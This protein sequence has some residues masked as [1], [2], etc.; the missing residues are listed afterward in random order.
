MAG[1]EGL[2]STVAQRNIIATTRPSPS[3]P[4]PSLP[5]GPCN[6]RDA[7]TGSCGCDQF[8][9]KCSAEIHNESA[10]RRPGSDRSTWC[11]CGHHA[12]FHRRVSR[13]FQELPPSMHTGLITQVEQKIHASHHVVDQEAPSGSTQAQSQQYAEARASAEGRIGQTGNTPSQAST[14]GLPMIPSVCMLS[15]DQD[16]ANRASRH[17]PNESRTNAGLGLS[18]LNLSCLGMSN[19]HH[20]NNNHERS[21]SP[22][23]PDDVSVCSPSGGVLKDVLEFNRNLQ[24]DVPGDTI[25]DTFNPEDYIQSATEVATP[26][27]RNTPDLGA[28]DKAVHEGRDFI[29]SLRRMTSTLQRPTSS[30]SQIQG[31]STPTP[32]AQQLLLTNSPSVPIEQVQRLLRSSSPQGVQQLVSYLGP[33]HNLLTSIPQVANTMRELGSRLDLLES[34]SF[35]YVQPEDLN[36]TLEMY[37]VRLHEVEERMNEHERYHQALDND[38]SSTSFNVRGSAELN[39][40]FGSNHSAHSTDSATLALVALDRKGTQAE[41]GSIKDR[42]EILEA[43]ALPSAYHPWEVEVIFLPWGRGLRGLWYSPDEPQH[44]IGRPTTQDSEEWTQARTTK[45]DKDFLAP[46]GQGDLSPVRMLVGSSVFHEPESGWSSQ[47]ISDWASESEKDWLFPKACGSKNL[48]YKRLHSRGFVRDVSFMG[49]SARDLQATL[50]DAFSDLLEHLNY[51][52]Y[53]QDPTVTTYPGLQAPFIPLRK[54]FKESKLQFLT[55][56][57]MS[58]S[59]LWS[60]QFLAS[61]V[62]MRVSGGKKR[63]YVTHREAYMQ[64]GEL[65][66]GSWSWSELRQLPRF[67]SDQEVRIEGNDEHCQPQVQEANAKEPC[68]Q[69]VEALDAPPLSVHSSFGSNQSVTVP[70]R[71]SGRQWRR[72]ITPSSILKNR[73]IQPISPYSEAHPTRPNHFR[74]RTASA[75]VLETFPPHSS[76][77]RFNSSPVKQSSAPLPASRAT[78]VSVTRQKRRRVQG[79]SSPQ[80]E[81]AALSEA[82]DDVCNPTPRRSREPPSPFFTT[83]PELRRAASD[84]TSRPSQRSIAVASKSAPFAYATPHSGPMLGGHF[85]GFNGGGDPEPDDDDELYENAS[86]ASWRG[87]TDGDGASSTSASSDADAGAEDPGSFSGDDSG[88]GS[89][90]GDDDNLSD[91]DD[92]SHNAQRPRY[93]E[94]EESSDDERNAQDEDEDDVFDSLLDVLEN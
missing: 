1:L 57:E 6:Y 52:N 40:S 47:A 83:Y 88:F 67:D 73:P 60:A 39:T 77:R 45:A 19:L 69:Y 31:H 16:H 17:L 64:Q 21:P 2:G 89:D 71:P 15:H 78:S 37:D 87:V 44:N 94:D 85:P 3:Q 93:D 53:D 48:V 32:P 42:L 49:A 38:Q 35:N 62:M 11:V 4:P 18:A 29:D 10:E 5:N 61:G 34:G 82:H 28:A 91:T 56:S 63:L 30:P 92:R 54:S 84:L 12:C 74:N 51:S 26:S 46:Q 80:P 66:S 8:W 23:I 55:P 81:D 79:S 25:P 20:S 86:E 22:T 72:S 90:T 65:S 9:D 59:A 13:A 24:L 50:S 75:S 36:Q 76:K 43:A 41:I 58:S 33:L 70:M 14:S 7:T 68:W 27:M